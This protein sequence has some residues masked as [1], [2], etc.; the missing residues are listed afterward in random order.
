MNNMAQIIQAQPEESLGATLKLL[1]HLLRNENQV[2][3]MVL[4]GENERAEKLLQTL[5]PRFN[6][7][8]DQEKIKEWIK[9]F[10][11]A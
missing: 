4:A 8:S 6:K 11:L 3:T 10:A 5:G 7:E 1:N 9:D 2:H